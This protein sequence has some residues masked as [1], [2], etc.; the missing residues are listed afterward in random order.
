MA[1]WQSSLPLQEDQPRVSEWLPDEILFSLCARHHW[2]SGNRRVDE[3]CRQLFGHSRQ[4]CSHDFPARVD[5][6]VARTQGMFGSAE[7][8]VLDH[9]LLAFYLAFRS[10][11]DATNAVAA[12]CAGG[13]GSIKARLGIL[14]SRFG[15]AHPLKACRQCMKLDKAELGVSHWRRDHQW[16]GA[17]TCDLHQ[18]ALDV[19]LAKVNASGRFGW[20]MPADVQFVP[21]VPIGVE[22][23]CLLHRLTQC[24][25]GV[26]RLER[27]FHFDPELLNAT[28]L[29][30]MHDMDLVRPGG[31]LRVDGLGRLLSAQLRG[32]SRIRGFEAVVDEDP[33][34]LASQYSRLLRGP[35][36]TPHPL[37]RLLLIAPIFESWTEFLNAY[38]LAHELHQPDPPATRRASVASKDPDPRKLR[39][40]QAMA[41]GQTAH[42][43]ACEMG[44]AM[45][46]A[47][48]W[49]ASAD[50]KVKRRPKRLT[51][52]LR[53]VAISRL[54]RGTDKAVVAEAVSASVQTITL[55]LRTEP[56]LQTAWHQA[57]L[58]R[59]HAAARTAWSRTAKRLGNP[60]PSQLRHMQPAVFAWLYRNDR[61]WLD[62]FARTL[63]AAPRTNHAAIRWDERDASLSNAVR[64]A[65][66]EVSA[67]SS[68]HSRVRLA[69]L[70]DAIP[71][72]KG[73]L[74][75]LDRLPLTRQAI[76]AATSS[77]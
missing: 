38:H 49:A 10:R 54:R 34:Q 61:A 57:R 12:V 30:R 73:R 26:G 55:L 19:G 75:K 52:Q 20:F 74:S 17:C 8:I 68:A 33:V 59:R 47:M 42:A 62:E 21:L 25:V 2:V 18:C 23:P 4:G 1:R 72:L 66:L 60:M 45:A 11:V 50:I 53:R 67:R 76:K 22:L 40:I 35:R 56:G 7:D 15:A 9:S 5:Y 32:L 36:G 43:A 14:A 69:Q 48:A 28:L 3:T 46:T 77:R 13:L 51:D 37:R 44:V 64:N 65:A 58:Q 24:A 41:R 16:P 27:G 29:H 31:S 39:V 70:C 63:E 71:E 6:F